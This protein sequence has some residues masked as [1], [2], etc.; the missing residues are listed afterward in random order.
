LV[1][2]LEHII[3]RPKVDVVAAKYLNDSVIEFPETLLEAVRNESIH[4]YDNAFEIIAHGL[5]LHRSKILT[6]DDL[7]ELIRSDREILE[8][9]LDSIYERRVKSLYAKI[10]EFISRAQVDTPAEYGVRLFDLRQACRLIAN[11]VK[12]IKHLRKNMTRYLAHENEA[13]RHEYNSLRLQLASLIRDIHELRSMDEVDRNIIELDAYRVAIEEESTVATG[14]L[15]ALIRQGKITPEMGTSLI[16]DHG[17]TRHAI[18]NLIEIAKTLFGSRDMDEM[19]AEEL[20]GLDEEEIEAV[21][22]SR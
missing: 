2:F 18:L 8:F 3:P 16:N 11:T 6:V 15:D 14:E 20:I 21:S 19:E 1:N 12:D 9:D 10:L 4:L 22:T 13:I 5:N 7:E 17:Y